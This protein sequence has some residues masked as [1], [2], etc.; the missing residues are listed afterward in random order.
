MVFPML[1]LKTGRVVSFRDVYSFD[2]VVQPELSEH[3]LVKLKCIKKL[4]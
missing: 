1:Y 3:V 2:S 4:K